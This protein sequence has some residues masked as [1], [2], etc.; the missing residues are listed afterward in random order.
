MGQRHIYLA[1]LITIFQI[2][3]TADVVA[4][5]PT[6]N[7]V[8]Y[9]P[10][11]GNANDASGN[12][13]DAVNTNALLT[14]D[15]FGY[16]NKAYDFNGIDAYLEINNDFDFPERTINLWFYVDSIDVHG[17]IYDT[18]NP[19]LDYGQTKIF[20]THTDGQDTVEATIGIPHHTSLLERKKWHMI[21]LVRNSI[22][23]ISYLNC[24]RT[25]GKLNS[26]NSS[27]MGPNGTRVGT[28]RFYDRFFDGKIDDIRIYDRAL[29][30][31]EITMLYREGNPNLKTNAPSICP[32]DA[33]VMTPN[34]ADACVVCDIDGFTGRNVAA[35]FGE[36]PP[37]FQGECTVLQHKAAW[38][39][40]IAGSTNLKISMSV[41]NCA[42]GSGLELG[43]YAGTEC[44][45]F[46]RISNCHGGA[47]GTPI[48]PNQPRELE[49]FEPLVIGQYYYIVMDATPNGTTFE[50]C[51]WTLAVLEGST[52]IFPLNT[53]G[54]IIGNQLICPDIE[55]TYYTEIDTGA[56]EFIW[57]VDGVNQDVDNDSINLTF[58][59]AGSYRLCV[60]ASNACQFPDPTCTIVIV[61]DIPVTMIDTLVCESDCVTLA[62]TMIC[63]P[64]IYTRTYITDVGCD[65]LIRINYMEIPTPIVNVNLNICEEDTFYIGDQPFFETGVYQERLST[66]EQCDSIV[67]LDLLVVECNIE[68]TSVAGSVSCA[69][70][71]DGRIIFSVDQGTP[72]FTY[73]WQRIGG[74]ASGDGSIVAL[75]I[76]EEVTDL[77]PGQYAITV[78]DNFGN[79]DIILDEVVEPEE[80]LV[81]I[82]VSDYNGQDISCPRADDGMLICMASGGQSPYQFD[83]SNGRT[84]AVLNNL[85][86]DLYE[87]TV[88]DNLGCEVVAS[89]VISEPMPIEADIEVA[90]P[91]CNGLMTGSVIVGNAVGGTGMYEY[92]IEGQNWQMSPSFMGLGSGA[93]H[94]YFRDENLCVYG[95]EFNLTEPEIPI[96]ELDDDQSIVLGDSL[97]LEL[98][99]NDLTNP[100]I[101]WSPDIYLSCSDCINPY[102][103][104]ASSV[105][106]IV[107]VTSA[108]D[109]I[110]S[111]TIFIAVQKFRKFFAPTA[112]T[113]NQ[114]GI[115]DNFFISGGPEVAGIEKLSIYDRW[116]SQ[117]FAVENIPTSIADLGW[118]G[119]YNG[120]GLNAGTYIWVADILF[121]DGERINYSGEFILMR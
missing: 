5:I 18:D 59:I 101:N 8:A 56:T 41:D 43:I 32:T 117:V 107:S 3:S 49:V 82:T 39:A 71:N 115:N 63:D 52:E 47:T 28:T 15:R 60:Q 45:D 54:T 53:S 102:A 95:R 104:P 99:T 42:T 108:D 55:T 79:V 72:P 10:F 67:N 20:V 35:D 112:F 114:D 73:T 14:T 64:G 90:N 46:R 62:D 38:I 23:T 48:R 36:L 80:L 17:A 86:P 85:G 1:L 97:Q 78:N 40:F 30:D 31:E 34:C 70:G 37:G 75:G 93:Y 111:D 13:N 11:D 66:I 103:R 87:V 6:E 116:G 51:D 57:T 109:C 2:W 27:E 50:T 98:T 91:N 110:D 76:D 69:G 68:S 113:P 74:S 33:A 25:D 22:N 4:Q 105:E 24:R 96:V 83:W 16:A 94:V 100:R 26:D 44:G 9:Y 120:R 12:G 58:P 92:S 65:S 21:T 84:G 118:N 121:I 19:R 81:S 88:T 29:G 7:L 77:L 89:I 61:N 119:E 106:Y